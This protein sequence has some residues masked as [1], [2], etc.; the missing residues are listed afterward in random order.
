[1]MGLTGLRP[2]NKQGWLVP[3]GGVGE[4]GIHCL[5]FPASRDC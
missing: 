4:Q 5:P 2:R 3:E 1:M